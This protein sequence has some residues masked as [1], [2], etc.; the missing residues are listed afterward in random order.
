MWPGTVQ[1]I[2][3]LLQLVLF[4]RKKFKCPLLVNVVTHSGSREIS[5]NQIIICCFRILSTETKQTHSHRIDFPFWLLVCQNSV[6]L[7]LQVSLSPVI[8]RVIMK[9]EPATGTLTITTAL[10]NFIFWNP[11]ILHVTMCLLFFSPRRCLQSAN[12]IRCAQSI[13]GRRLV[14]LASEYSRRMLLDSFSF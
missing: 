6:F 7:F 10:S 9:E 14:A 12:G 3:T 2:I 11:H 5:N 1:I 13:D 4:E 8:C